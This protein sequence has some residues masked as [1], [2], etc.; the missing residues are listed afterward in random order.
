[1][2]PESKTRTLLQLLF[3]SSILK[4][5]FKRSRRQM[6]QKCANNCCKNDILLEATPKMKNCVSIAPAR[7]DRGSCPLEN[8]TKSKENVTLEQTRQKAQQKG[9]LWDTFEALLMA[10]THQAR[11]KTALW[12]LHAPRHEKTQRFRRPRVLNTVKHMLWRAPGWNP[13]ARARRSGLLGK[14][15]FGT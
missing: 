10:K 5:L 4:C 7:A 11:D 1:M 3:S 8:H 15:R 13:A 2:E 12:S 14:Q 9:G 6:Y